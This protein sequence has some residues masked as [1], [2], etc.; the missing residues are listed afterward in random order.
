MAAN[1][2]FA[3]LL[4]GMGA[5]FAPRP[6]D[7][8][9]AYDSD[10]AYHRPRTSRRPRRNTFD[11]DTRHEPAYAAAPPPKPD[12]D[13]LRQARAAYYAPPPELAE[14]ADPRSGRRPSAASVALSSHPPTPPPPPVPVPDLPD[15]E[16]RLTRAASTR[17]TSRSK[18]QQPDERRPSRKEREDRDSGVYVYSTPRSGDS[19]SRR[20]E[21]LGDTRSRA[22][23]AHR[24]AVSSPA[25]NI[26]DVEVEREPE[27]EPEPSVRRADGARLNRYVLGIS[28]SSEPGR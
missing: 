24:R 5:I 28:L 25:T 11:H 3:S 22:G 8:A 16:P 4:D 19:R 20:E 12:L 26:I 9:F 10:S 1:R 23:G 2:R 15:M 27:P 18:R 21:D 14:L 17:K 13:H 7:H 6:R